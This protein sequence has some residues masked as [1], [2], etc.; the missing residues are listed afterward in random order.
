[1]AKK[2][3]VPQEIAL[4][5]D[6]AER[7]DWYSRGGK[8]TAK[9]GDDIGPLLGVPRLGRTKV[10]HMKTILESVG[11]TW[12]S[13]RHSSEDRENP[14]GNVRKEAYEDLLT[15]LRR[16][17]DDADNREALDSLTVPPNPYVQRLVALRHGQQTFR[18]E[19]LVAYDR[20]CAITGSGVTSILEAAHIKPFSKGGQQLP[21]NGLLLRADVH[22]LFDQGLIGIDGKS[23]KVLV[24]ESL[25]GTEYEQ[26][27]GKTVA[28]PKPFAYRPNKAALDE[29]RA[30]H[31]L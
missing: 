11:V 14:G 18:A 17:L 5:L 25:N 30:L 21:S 2:Q 1:M 29:H 19:L 7:P 12:D 3:E 20:Q 31:D 8:V 16:S 23:L 28:S 10:E 4:L 26:F 9:F 13:E 24:H 27:R 22:S 6:V 15:E